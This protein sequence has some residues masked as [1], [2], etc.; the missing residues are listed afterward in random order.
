MH[1]ARGL[2]HTYPVLGSE[3]GRA[4]LGAAGCA[5][6]GEMPPVLQPRST[7]GRARLAAP[8]QKLL[9]MRGCAHLHLALYAK[10]FLKRL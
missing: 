6:D 9:L 7:G 1:S 4:S 3:E 2:L 8:G 5:G 10:L